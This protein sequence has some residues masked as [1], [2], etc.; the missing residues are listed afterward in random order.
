M[1]QKQWLY[2]AGN[3]VLS[4]VL[5]LVAV[6]LGHLLASCFNGSAR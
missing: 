2:A 4:V 6:W 5:C 1:Q 3:A